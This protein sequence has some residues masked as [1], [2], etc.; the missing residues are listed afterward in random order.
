MTLITLGV[1]VFLVCQSVAAAFYARKPPLGTLHHRDYFYVGGSYTQDG[2]AIVADGQIYV[3]HLVPAQV[4]KPLPIVFIHGRGQT[5][6]NFL[7]TPDGR[8]S[9][10]DLFCER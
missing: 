8:L 5:G 2:T 4:T 6:T 7:N 10:A 1:I 3:E 9:W